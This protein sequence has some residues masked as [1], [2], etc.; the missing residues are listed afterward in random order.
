MS[1]TEDVWAYKILTHG[2]WLKTQGQDFVD[3][4]ENDIAD[5]FVHLS[6]KS[7]VLATVERYFS[8]V[9]ELSLLRFPIEKLGN[10]LR[11]ETSRHN[12]DFP[13]YYG[14]LLVSLSD[15]HYLI[16]NDPI[17]R[18]TFLRGLA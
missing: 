13:H 5:G 18:G 3:R 8:N 4:G 17:L 12:E 9:T 15:A 11:I 7:Q 1:L 10:D 16:P 6:F 2:Q 14:N